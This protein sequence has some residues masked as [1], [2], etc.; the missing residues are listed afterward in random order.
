MEY[1]FKLEDKDCVMFYESCLKFKENNIPTNDTWNNLSKDNL[2]RAMCL[3]EELD[4]CT[5]ENPQ[6]KEQY[7]S[8]MVFLQLFILHASK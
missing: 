8:C 3:M 5:K 4:R 6:L 7:K 2:N 1:E